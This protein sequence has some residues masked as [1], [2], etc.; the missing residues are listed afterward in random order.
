MQGLGISTHGRQTCSDPVPTYPAPLLLPQLAPFSILEIPF[1][2][3]NKITVSTD[4]FEGTCEPPDTLP[5][6]SSPLYSSGSSGPQTGRDRG[7]P[8]TGCGRRG[9]ERPH[10][11]SQ[12]SQVIVAHLAVP[13]VEEVGSPGKDIRKAGFWPR[14]WP[15]LLDDLE[16]VPA[17]LWALVPSSMK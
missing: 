17:P 14:L 12:C 13:L 8:C 16:Q 1:D 7:C 15:A 3:G 4:D 10:R 2:L 6:D 5:G 11:G 9:R